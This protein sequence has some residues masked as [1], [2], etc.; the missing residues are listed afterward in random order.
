MP[1]VSKSQSTILVLIGGHWNGILIGRSWQAHPC[2]W[3]VDALTYLLCSHAT[4]STL[5]I[6]ELKQDSEYSLHDGCGLC[7]NKLELLIITIKCIEHVMQM[8][9]PVASLLVGGMP[10]PVLKFLNGLSLNLHILMLS[11]SFPTVI[12]Y[13]TILHHHHHHHHLPKQMSLCC[14][15]LLLSVTFWF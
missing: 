6:R 9:F 5:V 12:I 4:V 13:F 2:G 14:I 11:V 7:G 3:C 10:E 1:Q 15:K 8:P